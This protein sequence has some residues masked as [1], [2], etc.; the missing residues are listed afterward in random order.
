VGGENKREKNWEITGVG[1][2]KDFFFYKKYPAV[3]HELSSPAV[4]HELPSPAVLHELP[5]SV[6]ACS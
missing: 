4:L 6:S 3:L 2:W 5:S 1:N